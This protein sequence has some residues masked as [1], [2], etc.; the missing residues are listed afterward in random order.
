MLIEFPQRDSPWSTSFKHALTSCTAL[1]AERELPKK[2][3]LEL[4][5]KFMK[6]L[7]K[8]KWDSGKAEL[9]EIHLTSSEGLENSE[10][11][12]KNI[13]RDCY[14]ARRIRES[15][16]AFRMPREQKKEFNEEEERLHVLK[17]HFEMKTE[18]RT[19]VL[20]FMERQKQKQGMSDLI[21]FSL[22]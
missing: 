6:P 11:S 7:K 5:E 22:H 3:K 13:L 1:D 4:T 10:S 19:S 2:R 12:Q 20:E 16:K 18:L 14:E 21:E 8:T 15:T 17:N 9:K